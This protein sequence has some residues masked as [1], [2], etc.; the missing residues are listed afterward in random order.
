MCE[1]STTDMDMCSPNTKMQRCMYKWLLTFKFGFNKNLKNCTRL[2]ICNTF[3][4]I[5]LIPTHISCTKPNLLGVDA[6]ILESSAPKKKENR[7]GGGKKEEENEVIYDE[8]AVGINGCGV[9]LSGASL[10]RQAYS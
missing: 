3:W 5:I 2:K 1:F 7:K 9:K 8:W 4:S 10:R 6:K